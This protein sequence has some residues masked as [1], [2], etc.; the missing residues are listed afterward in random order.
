GARFALGLLLALPFELPVLIL[1]LI[2]GVDAETALDWLNAPALTA[3]LLIA[4]VLMVTLPV[5]LTL[6]LEALLMRALGRVRAGVISRWS[7]AYLRV[8]LKTQTVQSAS[9][10]LSGTLFWP[11]WLRLAGMKIR[12]NCGISTIMAVRTEA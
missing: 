1:A 6:A 8:W 9:E 7:P 5:P 4:G 11:L 12:R 10:W 3:S 2:Y